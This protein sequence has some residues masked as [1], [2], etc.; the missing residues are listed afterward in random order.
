MGRPAH[1]GIA[2]PKTL[3]SVGASLR[4]GVLVTGYM[5]VFSH[6]R[7]WLALR[8]EVKHPLILE[9]IPEYKVVKHLLGIPIFQKIFRNIW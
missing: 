3:Y 6:R 2:Y 9:N 1:L 8:K 5:L 7:R 4:L